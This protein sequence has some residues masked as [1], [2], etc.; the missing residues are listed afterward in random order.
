MFIYTIHHNVAV[1]L[2]AD[3]IIVVMNTPMAVIQGIQQQEIRKTRRTDH[4]ENRTVTGPGSK[5]PV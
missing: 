2:N 3:L 5:P 4:E 1:G